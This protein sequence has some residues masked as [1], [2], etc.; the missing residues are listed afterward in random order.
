MA[1]ARLPAGVSLQPS[2]TPTQTHLLRNLHT[3]HRLP[4]RRLSDSQIAGKQ[5]PVALSWGEVAQCF[6]AP[7]RVARRIIFYI[8]RRAVQRL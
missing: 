4:S 3:P 1:L 7:H 8:P 2:L 6:G 5:T